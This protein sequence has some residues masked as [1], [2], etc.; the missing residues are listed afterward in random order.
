MRRKLGWLIQVARGLE[1]A[2]ANGVVHRDI[3]PSNVRVLDNDDV[4]IMDFGIAK[5]LTA[6]LPLTQTG[7]MIGTAAYL[8]PEQL[9]GESVDGRSDVFS[10]GAMAYELLS[11]RRSF[12][13]ESLPTIFD[14]ILHEEPAAA[15]RRWP[16]IA[17]HAW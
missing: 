9:R 10:F 7:T 6:G 14:R 17:R 8:P 16:P 4:K 3:K 13:G 1:H 15:R 2:H 12:E 5:L 11:Y